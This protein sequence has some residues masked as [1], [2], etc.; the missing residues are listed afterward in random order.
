[1]A[2]AL[3]HELPTLEVYASDIS[4]KALAIARENAIRLLQEDER[5]L[6][7]DDRLLGSEAAIHFLEGDLFDPVPSIRF[8]LIVANPPYVASGEI[9]GLSREV[10]GEPL[11]ALDGG[12]DGLDLVRRIVEEAPAYLRPGG[13]LLL[14][15]DPRQMAAI[16]LILGKKGYRDIKLYQDLSG[17][18]RVIE[19]AAPPG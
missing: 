14:E 5:L 7:E 2:I 15:A 10:R 13:K 6:Q 16:A 18:D 8:S 11:L 19:G 12:E 4:A 1:V 3:K 9:P 17:Q